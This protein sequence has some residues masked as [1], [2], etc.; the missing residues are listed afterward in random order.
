MEV[1]QFIFELFEKELRS[2]QIQLLTKVATKKR[3]DVE[4]L[5]KEFLPEHLKLVSNTKTRIQVKKTHE[6]SLPPKAEVRCMARVWNRGKGGQ[7]TRE[8]IQS[9]YCSQHEKNRKHGRIDAPPSAEIFSHKST[10]LYK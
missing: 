8:R 10:S 9:D 7:C 1:P 3:L 4:E 6:P 5:I 2:I